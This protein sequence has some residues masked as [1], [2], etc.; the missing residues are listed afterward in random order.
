MMK[1]VI[2]KAEKV[3][4]GA[5]S[6]RAVSLVELGSVVVTAVSAARRFAQTGVNLLAKMDR[7]LNHYAT[8]QR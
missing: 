1:C 5:D 6:A 7:F 2:P 4:P 3:M 8:T